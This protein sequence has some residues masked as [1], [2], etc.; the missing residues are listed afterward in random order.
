MAAC[1]KCHDTISCKDLA[2]DGAA[3][4]KSCDEPTKL[5][6]QLQM[7][8]KDTASQL[9]KNFYRVLLYAYDQQHGGDFFGIAPSNLYHN[10]KDCEQVTRY[11]QMMMRFNVW[12][13]AELE[14]KNHYFVIKNT[15][16]K[17]D[18]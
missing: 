3:K 17:N 7:L 16:I 6:F 10:E 14:R 15:R 18:F 11:L 2:A 5:M 8:V 9:N 13:D 1:P 12:V 4:C